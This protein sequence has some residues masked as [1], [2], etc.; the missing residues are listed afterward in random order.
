MRVLCNVLEAAQMCTRSCTPLPYQQVLVAF[1][2]ALLN[3]SPPR[4][5][6]SIELVDTPIKSLPKL[7][8]VRRIQHYNVKSKLMPTNRSESHPSTKP[9]NHS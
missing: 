5:S 8:F 2:P 3:A 9:Q 6:G 7:D 1:H 4:I